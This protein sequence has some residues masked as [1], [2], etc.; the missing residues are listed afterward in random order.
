[1]LPE[2]T[3]QI[4]QILKPQSERLEIEFKQML[5]AFAE[6]FRQ[7]DCRL[8]LPTVRSALTEMDDAIQQIRDR[9]MLAGLP[10]E[11]PLRV[12]D[13]VERYHAT[14]DALDECGR[15]LCTLHIQRYWGDYG[16]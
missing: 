5:D 10:L 11:A 13:L 9:N 12:L 14:A 8:Q 3:E 7:G 2:I 15:F 16:L 6:C 4:L 1:M